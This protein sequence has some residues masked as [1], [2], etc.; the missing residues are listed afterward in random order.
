MDLHVAAV[1]R[2]LTAQNPSVIFSLGPRLV[3]RQMRRNP[4][5]LFIA[6]PKQARVHRL[7]SESVDQHVE[8]THG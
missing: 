4:Q 2:H 6:E 3:G 8:S 1:E 7:A 5:P